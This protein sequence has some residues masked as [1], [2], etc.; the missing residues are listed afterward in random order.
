MT[1]AELELRDKHYACQKVLADLGNPAGAYVEVI[2]RET[3]VASG[4]VPR[5]YWRLLVIVPGLSR[6]DVQFPAAD[7]PCEGCGTLYP[8]STLSYGACTSCWSAVPYAL[9][10]S[11]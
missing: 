10:L 3:F 8:A 1:Q 11:M 4:R 6:M 7:L 9:P 2:Q 5:D